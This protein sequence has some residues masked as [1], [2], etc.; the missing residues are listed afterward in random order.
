MKKN[1]NETRAFENVCRMLLERF[2]EPIG[3]SNATAGVHDERPKGTTG[4]G[5][6]EGCG[7][8]EAKCTCENLDELRASANPSEIGTTWEDLYIELGAVT[9]D[10]LASWIGT[11]NDVV[12]KNLP[13]FLMVNPKGEVIEK[14]MSGRMQEAEK[15]NLSTKKPAKTLAKDAKKVE[16]KP[17]KRQARSPKSPPQRC[18]V[19]LA[20]SN[21]MSLD[22]LRS[23]IREV[24]HHQSDTA[25]ALFVMHSPYTP[26]KWKYDHIG[27]VLDDGSLKDMSGHRSEDKPIKYRFEDV[28]DV[29]QMPIKKNDA[30]KQGLYQEKRLKTPVDVPDDSM[31]AINCGGF[32]KNV[33]S[34]N[35][36]EVPKSNII[37]D[38]WN[39]VRR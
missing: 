4:T 5:K 6:C 1:I 10:D 39:F 15:K 26:V 19:R 12:E 35:D 33:L 36:Y 31:G 23:L 22:D 21:S 7:M 32:V 8:D 20:K 28:E 14:G 34:A 38:I 24:L 11:T 16:D 9:L 30:I 17:I 27:F 2:G 37:D 13:K 3:D 25:V 29:F 18:D